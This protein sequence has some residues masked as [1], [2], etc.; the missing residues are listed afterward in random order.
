MDLAEETLNLALGL[1]PAPRTP[2][3]APEPV[4]GLTL[5]LPEPGRIE[6]VHGLEEI[7]SL[8][9]VSA[10]MPMCQPRDEFPAVDH[11]IPAVG[12]LV[13]GTTDRGQ[14]AD[15]YQRMTATVR[16]EMA[17]PTAPGVA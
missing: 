9:H 10:V 3:P 1:G 6:R 7:S 11:E 4:A 16:Y 14:L 5:F 13:S 15:L 12:V 8:P 17:A 2:R